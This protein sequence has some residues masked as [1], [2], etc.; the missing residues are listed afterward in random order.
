[1]VQCEGL[2]L[3]HASAKTLE[4]IGWNQAGDFSV[5]AEDL[6]H[7]ARA[8][9]GETPGRLQ[10]D[11]LDLWREA[12]VHERHLEFVLVVGDGSDATQNSRGAD[13]PGEVHH[14]A[15]EGGHRDIVQRARGPL[16]HFYAF[17]DREERILD[18]VVE[19]SY[20]EVLE[21]LRSAHDQ[22]PMAVGGRVKRTGI[23]CLDAH[24]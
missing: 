17:R 3:G 6:F 8:D 2:L 1:M 15:V 13:G 16:Q 23:K 19:H 5:K 4:Y 20:Y 7:H 12:A 11:C 22:V 21:E 9:E 24:G 14:E 18:G 10:E